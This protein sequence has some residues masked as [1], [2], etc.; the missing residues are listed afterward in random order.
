MIEII[1]YARPAGDAVLLLRQMVQEGF[2]IYLNLELYMPLLPIS[3]SPKNKI[4][5][6]KSWD[7]AVIP[8]PFSKMVHISGEPVY[9]SSEDSIE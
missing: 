1:R 2:I 6:N 3:C 8:L 7:K 5:I 4:V 9:I